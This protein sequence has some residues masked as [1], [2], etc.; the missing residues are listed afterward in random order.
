MAPGEMH[1]TL[2]SCSRAEEERGAW[3]ENEWGARE[4]ARTC[5]HIRKSLLVQTLLMSRMKKKGRGQQGQ[6]RSIL[7]VRALLPA[8]LLAPSPED[9][10]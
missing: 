9:K 5:H 10:R 8:T 7:R 6:E 1:T 4:T 3:P 2:T